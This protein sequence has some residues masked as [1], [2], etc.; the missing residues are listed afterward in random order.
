MNNIYFL[1][2]E[3]AELRSKIKSSLYQNVYSDTISNLNKYYRA[4]SFLWL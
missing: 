2:F 1:N 4:I 3:V